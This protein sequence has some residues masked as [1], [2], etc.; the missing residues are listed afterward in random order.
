MYIG[1]DDTDLTNFSARLYSFSYDRLD[2]SVMICEKVL[3]VLMC[4]FSVTSLHQRRWKC[5]RDYHTPLRALSAQHRVTIF[6]SLCWWWWR[7]IKDTG[8][9]WNHS[10]VDGKSFA[11]KSRHELVLIGLHSMKF[12]NSRRKCPESTANCY[13]FGI[14]EELLTSNT[15]N[16]MNFHSYH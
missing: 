8:G 11:H 12:P 13:W 9:R 15:E 14:F 1:N 7:Q 10:I 2:L 6:L 5:M 4:R 16:I 3:T